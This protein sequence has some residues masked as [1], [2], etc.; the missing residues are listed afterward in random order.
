MN[1]VDPIKTMP[2][3]RI[4]SLDK[5]SFFRKWKIDGWWDTKISPIFYRQTLSTLLSMLALL[6]SLL[7]TLALLLSFRFVP[8]FKNPVTTFCFKTIL[9]LLL[10]L[11]LLGLISQ[12][13][14]CWVDSHTEPRHASSYWSTLGMRPKWANH[15]AAFYTVH[16]LTSGSTVFL[17]RLGVFKS[18]HR[19]VRV[20]TVGKKADH[21]SFTSFSKHP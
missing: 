18:V 9:P 17:E 6:L 5:K 7:S 2:T 13:F 11:L 20:L 8:I 1:V 19:Y 16:T 14:L 21:W 15:K 12:N 10:P 4:R 3:L